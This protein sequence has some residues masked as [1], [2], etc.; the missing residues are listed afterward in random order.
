MVLH[1]ELVFALDHYVGAGVGIAVGDQHSLDHVSFAVKARRAG[2]KRGDRVGDRREDVVAHRDRARGHA[3]FLGGV[4]GD[5]RDRL[6]GVTDAT[7]RQHRLVELHEAEE[8]ACRELGR[9]DHRAHATHPSC[10]RDVDAEDARVRVRASNGR[11][12]EHSLSVQ[13]AAVLELALDLCHRVR[14]LDR[15]ADDAADPRP[16]W[17][18]AHRPYIPADARCTAS[19]I[20]P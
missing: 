11:A 9:C 20:F 16:D 15:L 4:R 19:R 6:A 7:G 5:D 13:V 10:S 12:E 14:P 17:R 2:L 3:S 1:R 8:L 18:D